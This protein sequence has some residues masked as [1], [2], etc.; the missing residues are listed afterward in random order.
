[1]IR[2]WICRYSGNDETGMPLLNITG[3]T[4]LSSFLINEKGAPPGALRKRRKMYENYKL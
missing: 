3:E 1:M 2:D 4:S